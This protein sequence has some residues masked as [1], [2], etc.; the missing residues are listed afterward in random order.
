MEIIQTRSPCLRVAFCIFI[1]LRETQAGRQLVLETA[2]VRAWCPSCWEGLPLESHLWNRVFCC[3]AGW[4]HGENFYIL[5]TSRFESTT[6][7]RFR[8]EET[9][10]PINEFYSQRTQG[11]Q[12]VVC[13]RFCVLPKHKRNPEHD[14]KYC[15]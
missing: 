2:S 1:Y 10:G 8:V 7:P 4:G 5:D 14:A 9:Q 13:S 3:G 6:S 11:N 12:P 15:T